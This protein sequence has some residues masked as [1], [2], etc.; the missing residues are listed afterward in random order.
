MFDPDGFFYPSCRCLE[1]VSF[2]R[3][4]SC[5][6]TSKGVEYARQHAGLSPKE[7]YTWGECF[8]PSV[9][10]RDHAIKN[11]LIKWRHA[12]VHLLCCEV[13]RL[14]LKASRAA[15][16]ESGN[17]RSGPSLSCVILGKSLYFSSLC[18]L[19]LEL[20][21]L[22]TRVVFFFLC[23]RGHGILPWIS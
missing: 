20:S 16:R 23:S 3:A 2:Q 14:Q 11:K 8:Q 6:V 13:Q 21:I 19:S 4:S 18:F 9:L 5:A 10:C 17:P 7:R 12:C 22:S 15:D 1:R